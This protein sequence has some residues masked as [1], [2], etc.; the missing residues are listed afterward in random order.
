MVSESRQPGASNKQLRKLVCWSR[1]AWVLPSVVT[2]RVTSGCDATGACVTRRE[3]GAHGARGGGT[4][5]IDPRCNVASYC[6]IPVT[7]ASHGDCNETLASCW[8]TLWQI[9]V[10]IY[11]KKVWSVVRLYSE[12][13]RAHGEGR[14]VRGALITTCHFDGVS[15]IVQEPVEFEGRH[16]IPELWNFPEFGGNVLGSWCYFHRWWI[17]WF[18]DVKLI[19]VFGLYFG[20]KN[21]GFPS[22]SYFISVLIRYRIRF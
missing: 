2:P 16:Y 22:F 7:Y 13:G 17:E 5:Y 4:R 1:A 19:Y 20:E 6:F 15:A 9:F 8:Q 10:S 12:R 14:S 11:R 21:I 3:R 18:R